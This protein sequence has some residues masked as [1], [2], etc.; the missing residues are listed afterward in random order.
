M[1]EQLLFETRRDFRDWLSE[2]CQTGGG[3]WLIFGKKGGPKTLTYQQALEEAL[4]FGWIDSLV[5]TVDDKTYMRYFAPR[6]RDSTW[7]ETNKALVLTLEEQGLMTEY[8]RMAV[9]AARENGKWDA[10]PPRQI[11]D[12]QVDILKTAL[13]G[14]E[15]AHTNFM[16]MSSSVQRTYAALY[17]DAKSEK[18]KITRLEKIVGR[19][20]QNLKPM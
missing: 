15:P 11:T 7:S 19:L 18:T 6:R 8:G 5:K 10:P 17:L 9:R 4:S 14:R 3:I 13:S 1:P 12:E 16:N 20:D 2:N